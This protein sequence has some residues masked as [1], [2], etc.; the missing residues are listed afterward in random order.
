MGT[1]GNDAAGEAGR[2][3]QGGTSTVGG[4]NLGGAKHGAVGGE[5]GDDG[6]ATRPSCRGLITNCGIDETDDCCLWLPVTGGDLARS[7]V[8]ESTSAHV[9][10]F[11][12]D[13]YE[14]TVGRFRNFLA[15]YDAWLRRG[16]LHEGVGAN[17]RVSGSGWR[18]SWNDQLAANASDLEARIKQCNGGAPTFDVT[19]AS[20]NLPINCLNWYEAFAFCAWDGER[21]P[22][23]LEWEYAAAGGE[24]QRLY[25]WGSSP[26]PTSAYAVYNCSFDLIGTPYDF[27]TLP[28]RPKVGSTP[29]GAGRWGQLDL[30]G[31]MAEWVFDSTLNYPYLCEDCAASSAFDV[32]RGFRGG[33]IISTGASDLETSRRNAEDASGRTFFQG[34]RCAESIPASCAASCSPNADCDASGGSVTCSCRAGFVADGSDCRRPTSCAELHEQQP[35]L[36]S[37]RYWLQ[38]LGSPE[39]LTRCEMSAQGG[40]WTLLFNQSSSFDPQALGEDNDCYTWRCID[41]AYSQLPLAADLMLDSSDSAISG[42]NYANRVVIEG[43]AGDAVGKTMR[44]LFTDGPFF[45]DRGSDADTTALPQVLVFGGIDTEC[46]PPRRFALSSGVS[47]AQVSDGCRGWPVPADGSVAEPLLNNVRLWIR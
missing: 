37:G 22:S 25:P 13:K 31:S 9:S 43:I 23:E 46:E 7:D 42:E 6:S 4:G 14:V 38:P 12:L 1:G 28:C 16:G 36:P 17:P 41:A 8:V 3:D 33:S 34:L 2:S 24:E 21:L 15:D 40:G 39:F 44:E 5:G 47:A 18:D 45:V 11:R 35:A 30:A 10:E 20:T 32:M 27:S 29:I 19:A 26:A